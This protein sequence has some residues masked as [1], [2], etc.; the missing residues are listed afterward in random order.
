MFCLLITLISASLAAPPIVSIEDAIAR[1]VGTP[2]VLP[3]V[4]VKFL[5][6]ASQYCTIG[7]TSSACLF[8]VAPTGIAG[9]ALPGERR[10]HRRR[11]QDLPRESTGQ[12]SHA[13]QV[14]YSR[15]GMHAPRRLHDAG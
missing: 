5:K 6:T 10:P 1:A 8:T 12:V 11:G 3:E 13:V 2:Y 4:E 9:V 15:G 14:R 7:D